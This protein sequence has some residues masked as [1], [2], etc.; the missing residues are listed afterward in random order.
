[1]EYYKNILKE[2]HTSAEVKRYL[3]STGKIGL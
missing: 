2:D 3:I 1:M